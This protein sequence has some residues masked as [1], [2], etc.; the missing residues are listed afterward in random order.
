MKSR[1][2]EIL[3]IIKDLGEF[4]N[5]HV[6]L[7]PYELATVR[8][9]KVSGE[10]SYYL[11]ASEEDSDDDN[12][13]NINYSEIKPYLIQMY[14]DTVLVVQHVGAN[15]FNKL[16]TTTIIPQFKGMFGLDM[17][18]MLV[19]TIGALTEGIAEEQ[20]KLF[21]AA[22]KLLNAFIHSL[23]ELYDMPIDTFYDDIEEYVFNE[24]AIKTDNYIVPAINKLK[25][26]FK[27][28]T[29]I[30]IFA[31]MDRRKTSPFV[32]F[33]VTLSNGES[34]MFKGTTPYKAFLG[35]TRFLNE[36]TKFRDVKFH[37]D[38][39]TKSFLNRYLIMFVRE[40]ELIENMADGFYP[41]LVPKGTK[42][43]DGFLEALIK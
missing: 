30:T 1:H 23:L 40:T 37:M 33:N 31:K 11:F 10:L 9:I 43:I 32:G 7:E 2:E 26:Q 35:A 28:K 38:I 19:K 5:E 6:L 15:D 29:P 42:D 25:T 27:G 17:I 34:I 14:I 8:L 3:D 22:V 21:G 18:N 24:L 16:T 41:V 39:K 4:D 13:I 20:P 12:N 36:K